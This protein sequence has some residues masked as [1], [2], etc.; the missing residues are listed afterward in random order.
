MKR[1]HPSHGSIHVRN[2]ARGVSYPELAGWK[3][4]PAWSRGATPWNEL[5]PFTIGPVEFEGVVCNTF[6]TFWQSF[7]VW[8]KVDRQTH[9]SW[10]W[11]AEEHVD[12]KGEPNEAWKKWHVALFANKHAVRRPNG[13]AIPLYAWFKGQKLNIIEARRQIY[14][15]YLQTQAV[16]GVA[17]NGQGWTRC[18]YFG[19]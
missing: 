19:T 16:P 11:P 1:D 10:S 15:P 9:W 3:N 17:A 8:Q 13:R 7:K 14:I 5:S 4:I 6:E 18:D 12:E 2:V